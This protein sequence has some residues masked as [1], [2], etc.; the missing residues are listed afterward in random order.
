MDYDS[1]SLFRPILWETGDDIRYT[2]SFLKPGYYGFPRV[3][4]YLLA[5]AA[6]IPPAIDLRYDMLYETP[7]WGILHEARFKSGVGHGSGG[8]SQTIQWG[9]FCRRNPDLADIKHCK[10]AAKEI[11]TSIKSGERRRA[12]RKIKEYKR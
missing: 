7:R 5:P 9:T 1:S 4:R 6:I 10:Y 8:L 11:I 3:K 2:F 12:T